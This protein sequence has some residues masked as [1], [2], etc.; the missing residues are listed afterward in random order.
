[1][2]GLALGHWAVL[3]WQLPVLTG[4]PGWFWHFIPKSTGPAWLIGLLVAG[5]AAGV[6]LALGGKG[7]ERARLAALVALG[8]G[9]QFGFAFLE[10]RGPQAI[11]DRIARTGHAEFARTAARHPPLGATLT[12]YEELVQRRALGQFA[13]S[14]PPGTLLLYLTT[15]RLANPGR[16]SGGY[17]ARLRRLQMAATW[18]WPVLA[19]LALIPLWHLARLLAGVETARLACLLYACVPSV[20]LI[21]LHAD[22]TLYP[23]LFT[24]TLLLGALAARRGSL[25][26]GL[27]SGVLLYAAVWASFGLAFAAPFLLALIAAAPLRAGARPDWRRQAAL[28]GAL[29]AGVVLADVAFRLLLDYDIVARFRGAAANHARWINKERLAA[30]DRSGAYWAALNTIEFAVW[31]GLPLVVLGALSVSAAVNAARRRRPVA[32]AGALALAL[33][34]VLGALA[35]AGGT[36]GETARLWLFLVPVVCLLAAHQLATRWGAI[37]PRLIWAV[38]LLQLGTVYF[39]KVRQDFR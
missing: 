4:L 8:V 9:L 18:L 13:A 3:H 27:A 28:L 39:V 19:F 30:G 34:A 11:T 35:W 33:A 5:G 6:R 32:G 31:L 29:A 1:M 2:I 12:R 25:W 36:K 17:D 24:S 23:L 22:Q 7:R 26:L 38:V 37:K 21:T 14:K 10:G 15:E 20:Q 16:D